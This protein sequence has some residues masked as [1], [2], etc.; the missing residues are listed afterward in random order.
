MTCAAGFNR[1]RPATAAAS[2]T[3]SVG[4]C[5]VAPT[6]CPPGHEPG[7]RPGWSSTRS[8]PPDGLALG[9]VQGADVEVTSDTR[10][11]ISTVF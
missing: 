2:V 5:A 7:W 8:R 1:P 6:I 9:S 10:S 4:C 3:A 11:R